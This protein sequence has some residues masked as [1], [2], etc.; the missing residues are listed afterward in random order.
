VNPYPK[1][2]IIGDYE[3]SSIAL[4]GNFGGNSREARYRIKG[5]CLKELVR[6]RIRS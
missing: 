3:R 4:I 6:P 2:N 1:P 5:A